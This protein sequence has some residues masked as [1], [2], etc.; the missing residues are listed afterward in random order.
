M[1]NPFVT[2]TKLSDEALMKRLQSRDNKAL[3]ELYNRYYKKLY[4]FSLKM[5][6]NDR[7]TANDIVQDVFLKLVNSPDKFNLEKKFKSWVYTITANECRKF[8]RLKPTQNIEDQELEI[9]TQDDNNESLSLFIQKLDNQLEQLSDKH[10]EAFIL[11]H[12]QNCSL[13]EIAEIQDCALG[14]VK[15]RLHYT[16]KFLAENLSQYKSMLTQ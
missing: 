8:F 11:K 4:Y 14:T 9:D 10:K 16:T 6:N 3:E 1:L 5:L 13:Q 2:Y 12:N 7:E 15:S